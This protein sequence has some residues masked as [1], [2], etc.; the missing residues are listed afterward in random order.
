M[1]QGDGD[2]TVVLHITSDGVPLKV[3]TFVESIKVIKTST[4]LTS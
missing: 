2:D 1:R 3:E 4:R